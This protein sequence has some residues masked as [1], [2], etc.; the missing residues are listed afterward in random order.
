MTLSAAVEPVPPIERLADD[1]V[2]DAKGDSLVVSSGMDG[3]LLATREIHD[4]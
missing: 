2:G 3:W 4:G 1:G